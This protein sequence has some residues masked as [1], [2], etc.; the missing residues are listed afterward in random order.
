MRVSRAEVVNFGYVYED[1][2]KREISEQMEPE[3]G[4]KDEGIREV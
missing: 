1:G 3:R 2:Q 4:Y